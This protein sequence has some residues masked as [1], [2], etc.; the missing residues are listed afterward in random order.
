MPDSAVWI[1]KAVFVGLILCCLGYIVWQMILAVRRFAAE[2]EAKAKATPL[3]DLSVSDP[4]RKERNTTMPTPG[5]IQAMQETARRALIHA[6]K[7]TPL[8][9][10][11]DRE[12][13][14]GETFVNPANGY[15]ESVGNCWLWCLLFGSF[16]FMSKGCWG[17]ALISLG[18][19]L[20]TSG[21]SWI[22][23]PFFAKDIVRRSYLRRGWVPAED[24]ER[25]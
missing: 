11:R 3:V 15:R 5:Q 1:I 21:I 8:E 14:S 9:P 23:Y 17:H 24:W 19:A 2:D 16:Y 4:A 7:I 25:R 10:M 20:P 12:G 13:R 6:G 18:L 22:A